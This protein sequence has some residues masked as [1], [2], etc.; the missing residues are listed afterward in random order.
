VLS[1]PREGFDL[2]L[3]AVSFLENHLSSGSGQFF[4]GSQPNFVDFGIFPYLEKVSKAIGS[5]RLK[6]TLL[7]HACSSGQVATGITQLLSHVFRW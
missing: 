2:F 1:S 3:E 4:G 6:T 5:K 7:K